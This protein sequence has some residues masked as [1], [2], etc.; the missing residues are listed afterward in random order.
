MPQFEEIARKVAAEV[1]IFRPS[2]RAH[3]RELRGTIGQPKKGFLETTALACRRQRSEIVQRGSSNLRLPNMLRQA[4]RKIINYEAIR[5]QNFKGG[6]YGF[7]QGLWRRLRCSRRR[8]DASGC[9]DGSSRD[10]ACACDGKVEP[11][12]SVGMVCRW[13][14][15]RPSRC[16]RRRRSWAGLARGASLLDRQVGPPR[17]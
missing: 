8:R 2:A 17:L 12:R 13:F 9:G 14:P 6:H 7:T 5:G 1:G 4:E 10:D 3:A 11:Q 16:L 15:R